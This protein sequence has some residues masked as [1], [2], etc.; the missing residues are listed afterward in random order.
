M[1]E[2]STANDNYHKHLEIARRYYHAHKEA[3]LEKRKEYY[4]KA[5]KQ[6]QRERRALQKVVRDE[7]YYLERFNKANDKWYYRG[8]LL[9]L[10]IRV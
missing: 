7:N 10:G 6:K 2:L 5:G 9:E 8:K 1:T 4:I 3:E